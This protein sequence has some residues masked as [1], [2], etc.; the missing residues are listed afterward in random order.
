MEVLGL[1]PKLAQLSVAILHSEQYV[2][3]PLGHYWMNNWDLPGILDT[4]C[5][6]LRFSRGLGLCKD[7]SI[8][9]NLRMFL[10]QITLSKLQIPSKLQDFHQQVW[11]KKAA[12]EATGEY[13]C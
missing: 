12:M 7:H 13:S 4:L 5:I 3:N 6:S 8:V 1:K 2:T 10:A 11:L 9:F